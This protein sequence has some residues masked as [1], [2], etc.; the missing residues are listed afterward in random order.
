MSD[1]RHNQAVLDRCNGLNDKAKRELD[2]AKECARQ[3][4]D[5]Q[6]Q[7]NEALDAAE[8]RQKT[9]A[10]W[11]AKSTAHQ[12]RADKLLAESR[13]LRSQVQGRIEERA[14]KLEGS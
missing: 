13:Q 11:L 9:A 2:F 4:H 5:Q 12:E 1:P 7:A 6:R 8:E 14:R 10:Y 3:A